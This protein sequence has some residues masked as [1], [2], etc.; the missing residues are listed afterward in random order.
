MDGDGHSHRKKTLNFS[1]ISFLNSSLSLSSYISLTGKIAQ[2]YEFM[3]GKVTF[4]GKPHVQHF[5][6]CLKYLGGLT[7]S[8]VA[9]VG[10]SLHHDVVGANL[11]GLDCIFV[12]GGVH[13]DELEEDATTTTSL[14]EEPKIPSRNML[15]QLFQKHD[16]TPTH[17]VPL[18][19]L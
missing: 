6:A 12:M 3:G 13:Y 14:G 1:V 11:T 9:H 18:F 2:H 8:R 5:Q 16:I 4:F 17:V 19:K 7:K 10:D 15:H